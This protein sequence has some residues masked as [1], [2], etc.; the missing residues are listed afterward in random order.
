M[1]TRSSNWA[2]HFNT[3]I[4]DDDLP[5]RG[6]Y[7]GLSEVFLLLIIASSSIDYYLLIDLR[8]FAQT[9]IRHR[10]KKQNTVSTNNCFGG[11]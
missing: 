1:E 5:H 2:L 10:N 4:I 8:Q 3:A 11:S 6:I 9:T 7:S